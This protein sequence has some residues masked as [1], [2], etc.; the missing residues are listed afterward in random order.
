MSSDTEPVVRRQF[1]AKS[2]PA[3]QLDEACKDE[4]VG[5][6]YERNWYIGQIVEIDTNLEEVFVSFLQRPPKAGQTTFKK[7]LRDECWVPFGRVLKKIA[8]PRKGPTGR[9]FIIE[10]PL[11]EELGLLLDD[12]LQTK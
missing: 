1:G 10:L 9:N 2:L 8:A 12:Y 3:I 4:W 11:Q 5:C 7:S 6:V